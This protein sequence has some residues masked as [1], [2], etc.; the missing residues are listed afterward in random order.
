ME[1]EATLPL[2]A[3]MEDRVTVLTAIYGMINGHLMTPALNET[4][5]NGNFQDSYRILFIVMC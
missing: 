5:R 3:V 2:M 1:I 4:N